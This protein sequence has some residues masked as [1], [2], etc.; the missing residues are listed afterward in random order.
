MI[1]ISVGEVMFA[2]KILTMTWTLL[3]PRGQL[4]SIFLRFSQLNGVSVSLQSG[5]VTAAAL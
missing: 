1:L 2:N 4:I 3:L 5:S